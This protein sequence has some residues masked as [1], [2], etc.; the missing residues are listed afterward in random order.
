M[1]YLHHNQDHWW[2]TQRH[3]RLAVSEFTLVYW[4]WSFIGLKKRNKHQIQQTRWFQIRLAFDF[5]REIPS[6]FKGEFSNNDE[7]G[8]YQ[9]SLP[10]LLQH[11]FW[12]EKKQIT[13]YAQA[14]TPSF[15]KYVENR[16][17]YLHGNLFIIYFI[18]LKWQLHF[19]FLLY[20]EQKIGLFKNC[21]FFWSGKDIY[22]S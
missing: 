16:H 1:I 14:L 5:Y 2:W 13:N 20:P 21:N 7:N 9:E 8:S 10:P 18:I 17:I 3:Y 11:N 12:W 22:L 6:C 4:H 19:L 15:L